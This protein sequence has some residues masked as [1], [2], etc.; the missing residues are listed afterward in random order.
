MAH[1]NI[2]DVIAHILEDPAL[3]KSEKISRLEK[4]R[5]E[6][7]AEMRAASESAMV[8]DIETGDDLK[9]LDLALDDLGSDQ[10]SIEDKG[11]ATL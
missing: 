4:M 6:A 8:D 10:N 5:E 1:Q 2:N 9:R 11:G 3:A 7:R